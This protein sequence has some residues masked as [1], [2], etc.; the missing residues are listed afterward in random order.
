MRS[1]TGDR[2]RARTR[3]IGLRRE[4]Q[5]PIPTVMPLLSRP[6]TSSGVIVLSRAYGAAV[7]T[8]HASLP[9]VSRP[10]RRSRRGSPRR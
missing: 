1:V 8:V 5:P 10:G 3:A 2:S 6:T 7:V 9:K 4:P